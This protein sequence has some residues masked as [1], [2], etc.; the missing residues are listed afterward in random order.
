MALSK[1]SDLVRFFSNVSV[2]S[3]GLLSIDQEFK[4]AIQKN[5]S[6]SSD[7]NVRMNRTKY[8]NVN[9]LDYKN[10]F[11]SLDHRSVVRSNLIF[12]ELRSTLRSIDPICK[13]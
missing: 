5:S 12:T 10:V 4:T 2:S 3:R 1:N 13:P 8:V 11:L 7:I 9:Y 6:S